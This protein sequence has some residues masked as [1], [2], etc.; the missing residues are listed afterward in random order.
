MMQS[1]MIDRCVIDEFTAGNLIKLN[2]GSLIGHKSF[3]L[4][5][6]NRN[7]FFSNIL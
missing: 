3:H 2:T 4:S 1:L 7:Q 5:P 6:Q